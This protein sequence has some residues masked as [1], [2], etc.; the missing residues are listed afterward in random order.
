MSENAAI[1]TATPS[2]ASGDVSPSTQSPANNTPNNQTE[3]S[4]GSGNERHS[5]SNNNNSNRTG[6]FRIS[7]NVVDS[8]DR[9]FYG[10][11]PAISVVLGLPTE[12]IDKKTLFDNFRE[13]LANYILTNLKDA[14][15]VIQLVEEQV[16]PRESFKKTTSQRHLRMSR[17]RMTLKS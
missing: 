6:F 9:T 10:D 11:T 5:N 3:A 15:D 4:T 7:R 13:K 16:D 12:R 14:Q 17:K 8:T 2:N 1:P